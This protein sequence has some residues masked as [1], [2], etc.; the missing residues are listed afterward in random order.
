MSKQIDH[1]ELANK[2]NSVLG[3]EGEGENEAK[4]MK[5]YYDSCGESKPAAQVGEVRV[6]SE[7]EISQQIDMEMMADKAH[8]EEMM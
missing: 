2:E 7:V 5:E 1:F 8:E 6:L 3:A 4:L